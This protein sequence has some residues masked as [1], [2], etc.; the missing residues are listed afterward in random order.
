MI[1]YSFGILNMTLLGPWLE[2]IV[3]QA[4]MSRTCFGEEEEAKGKVENENDFEWVEYK[5][6]KGV[7]EYIGS[8][9][10]DQITL[11]SLSIWKSRLP[12]HMW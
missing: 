12:Q 10:F 5:S 11:C 4:E 1:I 8:N 3:A 7:I 6:P 2:S 9:V